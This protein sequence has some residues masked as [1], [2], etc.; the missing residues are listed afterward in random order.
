MALL[1]FL[2]ILISACS[3]GGGGGGETP[4]VNNTTW[5]ELIWND[6]TVD[7]TRNWAD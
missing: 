1:F 6:G 7:K 2:A 4:S 5:D 3:S